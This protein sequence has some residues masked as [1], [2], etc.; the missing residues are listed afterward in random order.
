MCVIGQADG[1][2]E[3]DRKTDDVID[4]RAQITMTSASEVGGAEDEGV[5]ICQNCGP[6]GDRRSVRK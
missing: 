1:G 4:L 3:R 6:L 5:R 2:Q